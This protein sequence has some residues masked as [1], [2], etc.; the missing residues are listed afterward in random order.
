MEDVFSLSNFLARFPDDTA[1]FEEIKKQ[2]FPK[3][4]RCIVC[5]KI[6]RHYKLQSRS[7][8]SCKFCR[9]QT[10]PLAGTLFEKSSTP[11]RVW[12]LALFL[13]THTRDGISSKQLQRELGMTY[14]TAWRIHKNIRML[15]EQNNGDLLKRTIDKDKYREHKWVFFNKLEIS[16][17]EKNES[18]T[19]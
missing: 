16:W 17:V 3:G 5:R 4:I 19:E 7:A 6:T 13:M 8:Y 9:K 18:P 15:M 10:Y 2:R 12:F 14:K 11:L 1:C